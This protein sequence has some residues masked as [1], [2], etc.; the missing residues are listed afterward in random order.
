MRVKVLKMGYAMRVG[1]AE[2]RKGN[3]CGEHIESSVNTIID[4]SARNRDV[5]AAYRDIQIIK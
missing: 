1:G 2:S 5:R 3:G 4:M